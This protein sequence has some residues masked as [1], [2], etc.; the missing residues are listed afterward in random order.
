MHL[1]QLAQLMLQEKFLELQVVEQ[2]AAAQMAEQL[3]PPIPE[4]GYL[5]S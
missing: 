4:E 5:V 3:D 2:M 1:V